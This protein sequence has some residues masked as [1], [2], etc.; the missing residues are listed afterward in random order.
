MNKPVSRRWEWIDAVTFIA[1][2]M[3]GLTLGATAFYAYEPK[4]ARPELRFYQDW[5][6]GDL[7]VIPQLERDLPEADVFV[8]SSL[9]RKLKSFGLLLHGMGRWLCASQYQRNPLK[10]RRCYR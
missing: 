5:T 2:I 10:K 4:V 6:D 1:A 7:G 9:D 3:P 8:R